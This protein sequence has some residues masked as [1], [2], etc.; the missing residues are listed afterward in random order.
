MTKR[1]SRKLAQRLIGEWRSDRKR[2]IEAWRGYPPGSPKF[3]KILRRDLG[4]LSLRYTKSRC[5]SDFEGM[6]SSE[7]YRVVWTGK[8]SLFVVSCSGPQEAGQHIHFSSPTQY[9]VHVG[10]YWE[11]FTKVTP[12]N[13]LQQAV[14]DKVPA[15]I[16]QRAAGEPGR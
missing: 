6:R 4:K 7:R 8:D 12:N 1:V 10:K 9:W 14:R 5:F 16:A 3:Q 13:R 15:S 11:Y 2:T